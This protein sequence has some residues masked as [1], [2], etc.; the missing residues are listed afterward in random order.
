MSQHFKRA[1]H[2]WQRRAFGQEE[3]ACWSGNVF[4]KT[5]VVLP[6]IVWSTFEHPQD[7]ITPTVP[8]Q[9]QSA[10]M[11]NRCFLKKKK[12]HLNVLYQHE[13]AMDKIQ[14]KLS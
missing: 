8:P 9:T 13:G 4:M 10:A 5:C 12:Q 3:K 7:V 2:V 14:V 6:R 1:A 11:K